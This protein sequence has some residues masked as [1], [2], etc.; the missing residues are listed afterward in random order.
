MTVD[1]LINNAGTGDYGPFAERSPE[2]QSDIVKLN[3]L[4][5][6]EM[7]SL[8]LPQMQQRGSGA[9]INVGS[10]TG[11]QPIPYLA[12]YSASKAFALRFSEALWAENRTKGVQIM[13]LCPGPTR[14]NFFSQA[15]MERNPELME[16]QSYE[17][18]QDV[19]KKALK[20]LSSGKSNL[21]TGGWRNHVVVNASRLAP[22]ELLA[23]AL[24]LRFR[25]PTR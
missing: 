10:I 8:F 19:V 25:P 13:A 16:S 2:R 18:P 23:K 14:T 22:R 1:L 6:V 24:E 5:L 9:I 21:V 20:A 7:T 4:A 11:F 17:D 12:V 15:D 3:V